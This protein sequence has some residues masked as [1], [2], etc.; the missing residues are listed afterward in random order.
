M[1][2][3]GKE[4]RTWNCIGLSLSS[5]FP[6]YQLCFWVGHS[7]SPALD[8]YCT[9]TYNL[10]GARLVCRVY[11]ELSSSLVLIWIGFPSKAISDGHFLCF[12]GKRKKL[13]MWPCLYPH[14]GFL[15]SLSLLLSKPRP[16]L[17]SVYAYGAWLEGWSKSSNI[18]FYWGDL[19]SVIWF[20][21]DSI[22]LLQNE[23]RL[24]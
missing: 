10:H 22:S 24:W 13:W 1:R 23:F 21:W 12:P 14:P 9:L 6:V 5:V 16:C 3:R 4:H 20:L 18:N 7:T 2:P 8:P 19:E 11:K 15:E 17:T